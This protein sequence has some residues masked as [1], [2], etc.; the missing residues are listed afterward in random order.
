MSPQPELLVWYSDVKVQELALCESY[1]QSCWKMWSH[2]LKLLGSGPEAEM[3]KTLVSSFHLLGCQQCLPES[4]TLKLKALS[5]VSILVTRT[6][7]ALQ[8]AHTEILLAVGLPAPARMGREG[9]HIP[10]N[11]VSAWKLARKIDI[12]L[13]GLVVIGRQADKTDRYLI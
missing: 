13:V 1:V 4:E 9:L 3:I 8:S 6:R 5:D 7:G 10:G 11:Y 2:R 12:L